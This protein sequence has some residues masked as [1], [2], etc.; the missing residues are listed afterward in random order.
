MPGGA[1]PIQR[2]GEDVDR[3]RMMFSLSQAV[4]HPAVSGSQIQNVERPAGFELQ[5]AR[6]PRNSDRSYPG[7]PT[8][9]HAFRSSPCTA[10][11]N[12]TRDHRSRAP[13]PF[14]WSSIPSESDHRI[15]GA[16]GSRRAECLR[17]I[18][19]DSRRKGRFSPLRGAFQLAGRGE[20]RRTAQLQRTLLHFRDS[21]LIRRVPHRKP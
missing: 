1:Q 11:P 18:P 4:R 17:P 6:V 13:Q 5:A 9:R 19:C 15:S 2:I 10:A 12:S 7:W 3:H 21:G 16:P 20:A 14:E 8:V